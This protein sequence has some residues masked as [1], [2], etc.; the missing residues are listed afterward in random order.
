MNNK[1]RIR[2]VDSYDNKYSC[3]VDR[4]RGFGGKWEQIASSETPEEAIEIIELARKWES[5]EQ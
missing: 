1:Y 5:Y 3:R 4:K 2:M